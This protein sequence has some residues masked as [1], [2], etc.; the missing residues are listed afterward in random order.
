MPFPRHIH[1]LEI[2]WGRNELAKGSS[3][4]NV[5]GILYSQT[6]GL[7]ARARHHLQIR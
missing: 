5:Q 6:L 3:S 1:F 2:F 7:P 4:Q